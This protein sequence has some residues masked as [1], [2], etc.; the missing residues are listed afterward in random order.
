MVGLSCASRDEKHGTVEWPISTLVL[1]SL[2]VLTC[3]YRKFVDMPLS[4]DKILVYPSIA[5]VEGGVSFDNI[6]K[7]DIIN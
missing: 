7:F 2:V 3:L 1:Q 6:R 5:K 4:K